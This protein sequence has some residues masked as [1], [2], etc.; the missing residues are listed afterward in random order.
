V[1]K[2]LIIEDDLSIAELEK[3]YLEVAGFEVVI[4]SDGLEGLTVLK[5]AD[6][7]FCLLIL[8]IMLPGLDGLE[9]L[10]QIKEDKGLTLR[11]IHDFY[12][13]K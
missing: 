6:N 5:E 12:L 13:Y 8:D 1:E 3:D 10:R 4:Y 2:I 11:S 7:S 9:I